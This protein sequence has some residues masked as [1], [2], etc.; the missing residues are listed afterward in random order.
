MWE[1]FVWYS[2]EEILPVGTIIYLQDGG[3]RYPIAE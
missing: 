3:L 1:V 2:S